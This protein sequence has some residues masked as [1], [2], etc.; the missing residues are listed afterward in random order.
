MARLA[1]RMVT[2]RPLQFFLGQKGGLDAASEALDETS[3]T[4]SSS[5][6]SYVQVFN[7]VSNGGQRWGED[8][9]R[10]ALMAALLLKIL[11]EAGYFPAQ[12]TTFEVAFVGSLL[13]RNLQV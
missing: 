13:L 9:L 1:L 10:R 7:L 4:A 2:S 3:D 12:A 11:K 8:N 5:D 6:N